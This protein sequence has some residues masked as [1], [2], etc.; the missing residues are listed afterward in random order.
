MEIFLDCLPCMMRQALE[1]A[2]MATD[3]EVLQS[4]IME[5]TLAILSKFKRFDTAPEIS[6][7]IQESIR[8]LTGV[9][10][11]YAAVKARDIEE[12]LRLEPLI[13]TYAQETGDSLPRAL[14]TAATG[15]VMDAALY[16]GYDLE[17]RLMQELKRPFE[18][19]D[20]ELFAGNLKQAKKILV[21]ADNAGEVVFDRILTEYLSKTH[22][23]IYAVRGRPILND[24]T[25][26][27]ALRAGM[28]PGVELISTG[29]AT[30][31][32]V[33]ALASEEFQA[34]F[35]SADLVISKGQGNY[36]ALSSPERDVYFLLKAKCQRIATALGVGLGAYVFKKVEGSRRE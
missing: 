2:K 19:T 1:A 20:Q 30:P 4:E 32:A 29:V 27:D 31:G 14:K 5:R 33:M 22:Q 10:D 25:L 18:I 26:V 11:P 7:V 17:N 8:E 3:D 21:I 9:Q 6:G 28:G 23:V 34:L 12:A 15:N 13:R 24:A 36:E 35:R 16:S